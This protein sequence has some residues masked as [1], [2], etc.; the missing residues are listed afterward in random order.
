MIFFIYGKMF[1]QIIVVIQ[2]LD[3]MLIKFKIMCKEDGYGWLVDYVDMMEV[4]YKCY[5]ILYVKYF[6]MMLVLDCEID[7]F[8]YM[9]IFDICKYVFDCEVSFGYFV[10]YF[11]YFGLCGEEDVQVL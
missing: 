4:V 3:L 2:V 8:W 11:L 6:E 9:Y 5:L 1:D 7:C 10:Y